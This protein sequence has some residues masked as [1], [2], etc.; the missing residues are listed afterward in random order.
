MIN[1]TVLTAMLETWDE[2]GDPLRFAL[3]A[4]APTPTDGEWPIDLSTY[5]LSVDG[6]ERGSVALSALG[7]VFQLRRRNLFRIDFGVND[8]TNR[9]QITHVAVLNAAEAN[10]LSIVKLTTAAIIDPGR[11]FIIRA[12]DLGLDIA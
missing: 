3:L 9:I 7:D 4:P 8:S 6:Y 1:P 10:I 5:E 12:T 2:H 11:R